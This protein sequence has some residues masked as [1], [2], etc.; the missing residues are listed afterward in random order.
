MNI[1]GPEWPATS[2][3]SWA[4]SQH[5]SP[6][7]AYYRSERSPQSNGWLTLGR[8]SYGLHGFSVLAIIGL[9]FF[10]MLN[11]YYEYQYVWA[12]VSDTLPFAY[13]FSAFW[14]DQPGS[15]LLWAFWD[16][17][18]GMWLI[19]KA[20]KW[21]A[22]VL[23]IMAL[24]QAFILS[25]L[26]GIHLVP[27]S[28]AF[29]IG[30]NPFLLLR[31]TV[32]APIFA[33]ADY[34]QL[35]TGKG[36]NPLLQNYWNVIH[37]PTMFLGFAS[38][39]VP[40][41]FALAGIWRRDYSGWIKPVLPWALFS[42]AIL[43]IGILMGSAWAYEALSFGGYWA[44]DPVENM[45]LVPWLVLIAGIH[46]N[47]IA[48]ST[49]QSIRSTAVFYALTFLSVLFSSFLTRSGV[50]QDSSVHAF[51]ELGL[52]WQLVGF[53]LFFTGLFFWPYFR[54]MRAM[55]PDLPEE[56]TMSREFWMFIG[57]LVL[58]FSAILITFTTSIPVYNK[59][60]DALGW[61]IGQDLSSWHRSMPL[62]P[63]SHYNKYQFW[64]VIFIALLSGV[65]SI[66]AIG[67][68]WL[69]IAGRPFFAV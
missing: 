45:S 6:H 56:A 38:T 64:I 18:L 20:G 61:M 8:W 9:L 67:I 16:V 60:A 58:I 27:D 65:L 17:V 52:E 31:D 57:S 36:L 40:F 14:E 59:L 47:L 30:Y 69:V 10:I 3:S 35:I 54:R 68:P 22:P 29:K 63:I 15:F 34:L 62:D 32:E 24:I 13:T 41:C 12:H 48:R 21:E 66:C 39:A 1:S 49:G 11:R 33:N 37:P 5:Y 43:G 42:G 25:M 4:L 46:T 51:T 2:P 7:F 19:W 28:E 44:W 26:L 55:A 50:L 23:L 53:L